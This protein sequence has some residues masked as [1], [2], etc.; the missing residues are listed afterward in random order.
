MCGTFEFKENNMGA[1]DS[2]QINLVKVLQPQSQINNASRP[3][4]APATSH[5][6]K[7]ISSDIPK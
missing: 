3:K 2:C 7:D 5:P 1:S 6:F 4:Q